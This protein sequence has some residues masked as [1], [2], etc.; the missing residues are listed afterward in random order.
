[1]LTCVFAGVS[2]S[3]Q[4]VAQYAIWFYEHVKPTMTFA[5]GLA[6]FLNK[7]N[8]LNEDLQLLEAIEAYL[9]DTSKGKQKLQ[10]N[11]ITP[12]LGIHRICNDLALGSAA[13]GLGHYKC[14]ASLAG[15]L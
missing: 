14:D 9:Y 13:L 11:V 5:G 1:M 3:I 10:V 6:R 8:N 7:T 2:R 12:P 4:V 15:V